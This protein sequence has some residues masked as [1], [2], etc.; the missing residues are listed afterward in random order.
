MNLKSL[1]LL[2]NYNEA[3][4][5][6]AFNHRQ[7]KTFSRGLRSSMNNLGNEDMIRLLTVEDNSMKKSLPFPTVLEDHEIVWLPRDFF[8]KEISFVSSFKDTDIC[9]P[10]F[11]Y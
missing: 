11:I 4:N 1:G 3:K 5:V 8:S 7:H 9:W 2:L 10:S 6:S